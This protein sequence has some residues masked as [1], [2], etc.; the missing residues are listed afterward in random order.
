[1]TEQVATNRAK[2]IARTETA[3]AT[4]TINQARAESAG[5]RQYIWRN[6]GDEAVRHSHKYY[7]GKK[8]DGQVFDWDKP[9][10]LSDGMT[11]HPGEFPNCRCFAE[12]LFTE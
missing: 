7:K 2:L 11:G 6:S 8:L 4:A 9:P 1:M 3:K 10:T 12:P 5:S